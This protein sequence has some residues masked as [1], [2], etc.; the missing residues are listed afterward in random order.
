MNAKKIILSLLMAAF[1]VCL[2]V[3]ALDAA[4]QKPQAKSKKPQS[5]ERIFIPK[6][7]KA[8]LQ[9]GM[10]TKQGRQDIPVTVFYNLFLPA[11]ENLH[12]IFFLKIKNSGLGFSPVGSAL[13]PETDNISGP[14]LQEAVAQQPAL[15]QASFNVFL[16]F[17]IMEKGEPKSFR[18]VY[19]PSSAQ[20]KGDT[21]DPEKEETYTVGYPLPPGQYLLAL[22]VTSLDLQKIGTAYYEFTLPDMSMA[23][24]LDT[25][26]VFFVKQ[27]DKMEAPETG[28][29]LHQGYCTYSI[30]KVVPN[31]EKMFAVG[32]N[33]DIFYFIFGAQ[34]N[35]E[36]RFDIEVNYEVKKGEQ[37]AIRW[38][39]QMY[40]SPL[41]SQPLPLK[42]T[43]QIK[44]GEDVR[45]EQ[46]DL[47]PGNYTLIIKIDDKVSGK[48]VTKTVDFEVK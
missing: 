4:G 23:K 9:E 11:Q 12:A 17:N 21:F 24:E 5:E 1:I 15:F 32:E 39:P 2:V 43:V 40:N 13:A 37:T 35:Q 38:T 10:L 14:A 48:S 47:E 7:I 30:L 28:T 3:P 19:V 8:A 20:I 42:Q 26:P 22:A 6:E 27:L 18:E 34:P 44:T 25:T 29:M 31:L 46:R 45:T 33:L 41:V 16:Q 36:Q